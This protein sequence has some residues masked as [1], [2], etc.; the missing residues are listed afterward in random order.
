MLQLVLNGIVTGSILVLGAIGLTLTY[1]IL[2]FAN[3]AHGD[4]M[5]LGAYTA[6]ILVMMNV[7]IIIAFPVAMA[8]T[9]LVGILIDTI[10]YRPLRKKGSIVLLISSVGVALLLRN[11]VQIIWGPQMRYYSTEIQ[12]AYILPLGLR[13]KPDQVMIILTA[14]AFIV[15][16][17][18]FLKKTRTG[19]AMRAMADN[20]DLAQITGIDTD[21]IIMW[22]WGIGCALAAAAGILLGM[23]VQL[24]P[25]M[26]WDLLLPIFA[27]AILGGIGK[28]Y[29]AMAGGIIIG[30]SQEISTAFISTAYKPAVSFVILILVLL[31]RPSG[32][33]GKEERWT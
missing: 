27:A 7:P 18:L 4:I 24:R 32:I 22:T 15:L 12:I 30:L 29:G 17:H 6:L 3:F 33:F 31:V 1:G 5:T 13:I 25:F 9:A 20:S 26:G 23:E 16:L 21:R 11:I 8:F 28:P 14:S 10:L 19:K 2:R